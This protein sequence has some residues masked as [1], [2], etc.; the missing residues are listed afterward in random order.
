MEEIQIYQT[1][2]LIY[3]FQMQ[4][5]SML[6]FDD[7]KAFVNEMFRITKKSDYSYSK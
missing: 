3:Q 5:L 6:S 7:Q 2:N 4:L 1:M